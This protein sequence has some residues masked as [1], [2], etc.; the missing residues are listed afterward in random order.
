MLA[1][2]GDKGSEVVHRGMRRAATRTTGSLL[3][4][5]AFAPRGQ[6]RNALITLVMTSAIPAMRQSVKP[7]PLPA[8]NEA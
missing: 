1:H 6:S 4:V 3:A 7:Q 5:D 2:A 8:L